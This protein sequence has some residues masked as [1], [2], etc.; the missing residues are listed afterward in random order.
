MFNPLYC[1]ILINI[2]TCGTFLSHFIFDKN[3]LH[4]NAAGFF[5][6]GFK[7]QRRIQSNVKHLMGHSKNE[8]SVLNSR[9]LNV[10][11]YFWAKQ[12]SAF[13]QNGTAIVSLHQNY[14]LY[15]DRIS[16]NC[17]ITRFIRITYTI[18]S[19]ITTG[20]WIPRQEI[21]LLS[22]AFLLNDW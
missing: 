19:V 2:L 13:S 8:N 5:C 15:N 22:A 16:W 14:I 21:F 7:I 11:V 6:L 20:C 12:S 1:N 10:N 17:N 9:K 4:R 18:L 3:L